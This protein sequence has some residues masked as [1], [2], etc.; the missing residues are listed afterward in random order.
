MTGHEAWHDFP[1]AG[2]SFEVSKW[3]QAVL[4]ECVRAKNSLILGS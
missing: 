2:A 1:K 4:A 3:L